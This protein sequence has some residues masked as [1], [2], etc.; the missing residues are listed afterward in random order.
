[1]LAKEIS[2]NMKRIWIWIISLVLVTGAVGCEQP[3]GETKCNHNNFCFFEE[4]S[5]V[6]GETGNDAYFYCSDCQKYLEALP[7]GGG[8][9]NIGEEKSYDDLFYINQHSYQEG[10]LQCMPQNGQDGQ[11]WYSCSN[12]GDT[13][14]DYFHESGIQTSFPWFQNLYEGDALLKKD[15]DVILSKTGELKVY[16]S[17]AF[18]NNPK[19]ELEKRF[20]LKQICEEIPIEQCQIEG[21]VGNEAGLYPIRV[22][23]QSN[24]LYVSEFNIM[25]LDKE[26]I[27]LTADEVDKKDYD[28]FEAEE[29]SLYDGAYGKPY[30]I[31]VDGRTTK[32]RG[33]SFDIEHSTGNNIKF[34]PITS[35]VGEK[36]QI[37][38][39]NC[40][41]IEYSNIVVASR[42]LTTA[43]QL[44]GIEKD[45]EPVSGLYRYCNN[46][47]ETKVVDSWG[48]EGY[49]KNY[50]G[51][52]LLGNN[53]DCKNYTYHAPCTRRAGDT[54]VIQAFQWGKATGFTGVFDGRGYCI[55]NPAFHMGG[56]LG[57]VG[58]ATIKNVGV[59]FAE[60]YPDQYPGYVSIWGLNN[61]K[62]YYE[63]CYFDV[64]FSTTQNHQSAVL[65][66]NAYGITA[67]NCV[68]QVKMREEDNDGNGA[69]V[70][71]PLSEFD[72]E[73]LLVVFERIDGQTP[74]TITHQ[75]YA[76]VTV[77][78]LEDVKQ[79]SGIIDFDCSVYADTDYFV[80]ENYIPIF[81]TTFEN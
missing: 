45:G 72:F 5:S 63:N 17:Y 2:M 4:K 54:C 30:G 53:I 57:E 76:G 52:F 60:F 9:Y 70:S 59:V 42:I 79:N 77:T 55:K 16:K 19:E 1:M 43:N 22:C 68:F 33:E 74:L 78:S 46:V 47:T 31:V 26:V 36:F 7:I 73:N 44:Q 69:L 37:I 49:I 3:M 38:T 13:A 24:P 61:Y 64:D 39:E 8:R 29:F 81:K 71:W 65:A 15:L 80:V 41:I 51:Y 23:L 27:Q 58:E 10:Q 35:P 32:D 48:F 66:R 67:K 25:V 21:M 56:F 34:L 18:T 12:C 40:R 20:N 50:H 11:I 14:V 6:C 62:T 28:I 75:E